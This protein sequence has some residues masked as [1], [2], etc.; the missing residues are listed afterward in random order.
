M[1][2]GLRVLAIQAVTGTA[3]LS[4][5][6]ILGA[7]V[8]N[9]MYTYQTNSEASA[10]DEKI[11][12]RVDFCRSI[13]ARRGKELLLATYNDQ[14]VSI[15]ELPLPGALCLVFFPQQSKPICFSSA[16]TNFT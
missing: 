12:V 4:S 1:V 15:L 16:C 3:T 11:N 2:N 8:G 7:V 5:V 13:V 9:C 6:S 14:G 10:D